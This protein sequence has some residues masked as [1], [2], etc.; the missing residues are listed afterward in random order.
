MVVENKENIS[1]TE[2]TASII[3][4]KRPNIDHLMKRMMI[5]RRKE[6]KKN[7]LLISVVSLTV[8]AVMSFSL[9]S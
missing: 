7:F 5:E 2:N 3:Q 4:K 9:Y 6:Q 1:I 8:V